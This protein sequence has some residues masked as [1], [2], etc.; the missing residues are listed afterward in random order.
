MNLKSVEEYS[1][2]PGITRVVTLR[3]TDKLNLMNVVIGIDIYFAAIQY[4]MRFP[5]IAL[6]TLS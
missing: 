3:H 2:Y 5:Y 1:K 4:L 6:I